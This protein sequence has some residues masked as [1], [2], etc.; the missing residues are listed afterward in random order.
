MRPN[1]EIP[2][3]R[4]LCPLVPE[5]VCNLLPLSTPSRLKDG[6]DNTDVDEQ[7]QIREWGGQKLWSPPG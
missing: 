5:M 2:L 4:Y 3:W 7:G 1:I 6:V